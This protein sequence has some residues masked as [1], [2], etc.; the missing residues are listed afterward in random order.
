MAKGKLKKLT[1][2]NQDHSKSSEPG[3]PTTVIPEYPN[4]PENQDSYLK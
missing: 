1:N 4:T 3:K 2:R